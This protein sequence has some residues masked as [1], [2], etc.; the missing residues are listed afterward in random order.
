MYI[1]VGYLFGQQK[2][3]WEN[4]GTDEWHNDKQLN[5]KTGSI[6]FTGILD[7][8]LLSSFN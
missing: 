1:F 2:D 6:F 3:S 4:D 7:Y 5:P 8:F